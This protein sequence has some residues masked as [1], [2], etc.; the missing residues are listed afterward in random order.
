MESKKILEFLRCIIEKQKQR[1]P[2][3]ITLASHPALS[4][5]CSSPSNALLSA[6]HPMGFHLLLVLCLLIPLSI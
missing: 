3:F 5:N 2:I 6:T 4:A 1:M